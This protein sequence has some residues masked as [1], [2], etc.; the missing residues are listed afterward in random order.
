MGRIQDCS[1]GIGPYSK[2]STELG[3]IQNC[4]NG[5]EPYSKFL[6]GIGPYS[7][8]QTESHIQNK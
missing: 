7:I 8:V 3:H 2:F 1:N 4:P 6:N 5:I